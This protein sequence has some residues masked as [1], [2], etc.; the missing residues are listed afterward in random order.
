ML[1][2]HFSKLGTFH[3]GSVNVSLGIVPFWVGASASTLYG[4]FL[5]YLGQAF[6]A[7]CLTQKGLH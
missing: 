4:K 7:L 2:V 5:H 3:P 1:A 6:V